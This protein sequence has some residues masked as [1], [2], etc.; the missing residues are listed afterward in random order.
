MYP[1]IDLHSGGTIQGMISAC[2][3]AL[4]LADSN[5]MVIPGHGPLTDIA[6]FRDYTDMLI[7]IT[8]KVEALKT[9]GGDLK[10][11]VDQADAITGPYEERF[12]S[13]FISAKDLLTFVFES[14]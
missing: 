8:G 6:A 11:V 1:F 9:E 13:G 12:G 5:T 2:G 10:A 14:L 4:E 3:S 7:D